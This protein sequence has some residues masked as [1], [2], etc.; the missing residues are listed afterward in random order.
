MAPLIPAAFAGAG[1]FVALYESVEE[2]QRMQSPVDTLG[3]AV[4]ASLPGQEAVEQFRLEVG[5]GEP[6]G[7]PYLPT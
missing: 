2:P 7:V 1:Q 3:M 5:Q 6:L 4:A